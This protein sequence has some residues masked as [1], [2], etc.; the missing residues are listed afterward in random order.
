M[1]DNSLMTSFFSLGATREELLDSLYR[2][3]SQGWLTFPIIAKR[4]GRPCFSTNE[5]VPETIPI[6]HQATV[7]K[8]GDRWV[9]SGHGPITLEKEK[10]YA[11]LTHLLASLP[12]GERWCINSTQMEDDGLTIA[13]AIKSCTATAVSDGS[14]K[15]GY[16]TA[17]WV[18]EGTDSS[19]RIVGQ[20]IAPGDSKDQS[21]YRSELAGIFSIMVIIE[22]H[23]YFYG[24]LEGEITIGCDGLSA[25]NRAFSVVSILDPS[26][27]L[28]GAIKHYW[29][30]STIQWKIWHVE[31]HQDDHT[32]VHKLDRWSKL[33][34]K[35]DKL[36]KD[37]MR[38]A[39]SQPRHFEIQSEPCSLW[40]GGEKISRKLSEK[41]YERVHVKE[42]QDYWES[43][44]IPH[45]CFYSVHWD[46][47]GQALKSYP[48][49]TRVF[50]TKHTV[51][52]CGVGKFMHR[53]KE[54]D[55]PN[56]PRCGCFE[57]APH[58]WTCKGED[59]N[60]VWDKFLLSLSQW[61]KEMQTDPDLAGFF[62]GA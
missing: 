41:L 2:R 50:I 34:I 19:G 49:H 11:S 28:L 58:V 9:C 29:A 25:L 59:S 3:S 45:R 60:A 38:T 21:A 1:G 10:N 35:M 16:G 23:C 24:I 13:T 61:L 4:T 57:D 36:A 18:L 44:N 5:T 43:R 48:R 14:F 37:F 55:N 22:K 31:G 8:K 51:G 54:R 26:Y 56:C 39:R 53:W 15:D 20:V 62:W 6:L 30:H 46:A 52:M 33:N 12:N 47:V 17:A 7:Y 27:N 32:S 40:I 42:A